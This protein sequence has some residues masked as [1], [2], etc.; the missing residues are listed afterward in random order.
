MYKVAIS[1]ELVG[2]GCTIQQREKKK[3]LFYTINL[4]GMI[5][6]ILDEVFAYTIENYWSNGIQQYVDV[7]FYSWLSILFTIIL[8][9]LFKQL[10]DL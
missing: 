7:F 3:R 6:W 5:P 10:K 4:L 9:Y 2:G 8:C 1:V